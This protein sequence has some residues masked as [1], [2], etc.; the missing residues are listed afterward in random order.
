MLNGDGG[1]GRRSRGF[2]RVK[3]EGVNGEEHPRGDCVIGSNFS[4]AG[5]RSP[6]RRIRPD[7]SEVLRV[8]FTPAA[9]TP[10]HGVE[11]PVLENR[12]GPSPHFP[13]RDVAASTIQIWMQRPGRSLRLLAV[14]SSV[15][16]QKR[17]RFS[18]TGEHENRENQSPYLAFFLSSFLPRV[19]IV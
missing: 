2:A 10:E 15:P 8:N 11:Y 5:Q 3:R 1:G 19:Q 17:K 16:R 13:G 9:R 14:P 18:S 4:F 7:K 6:F 12:R